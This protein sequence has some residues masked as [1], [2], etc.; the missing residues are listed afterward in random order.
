[1]I[2]Y[3][4]GGL[5]DEKY[6][7]KWKRQRLLQVASARE[8]VSSL[9]TDLPNRGICPIDGIMTFPLVD[10][11]WV[12]QHHEDALILTLGI[13]DF[14]LRRILVDLGSLVDLLQ[15][16]AFKQMGFPSSAL[17]NPGRIL[18][19][20]NGAST[21]SLG[22]VVLPVQVGS[23]VQNVQF[24]VVE[25]LSPFNAIMGCTW[26]HNMKVIPSTYH[27]MVSCLTKNGHINLFGS[28]LVA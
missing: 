4:H 19:G 1:M 5:V 6:N 12:L 25:G 2:N 23:V 17:E 20:F 11:N 14:D 28:Q 22:D 26:L 18:S 7:S 27:Q 3:I 21:I 9:Q 13:N 24:S 16:S 10:P 15:M 8:Q